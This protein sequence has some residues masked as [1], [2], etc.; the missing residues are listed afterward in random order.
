MRVIAL[1]TVHNEERFIGNCLDHLLRQG[2][3]AYLIDHGSTDAT[4]AIARRYLHHG[5]VGMETMPHDGVFSLCHQLERKEELASRLSA[6]WFMHADADEVRLAPC[7]GQ[8]LQEALTQADDEGYSAVNFLEFAFTP[9]LEQPHHD[10]AEYE[11]TMRWYY[12]F[13]QEYPHRLNAWKKQAGRVNL[14]AHGGHRV[15]FPGLRQYPVDFPMRHYLFL[16]VEHAVE[17]Y[18]GRC[19]DPREV[20][21][22]AWHGWRARL[23]N[24]DLRLPSCRQ[25]RVYCSDQ[26]LDWSG[27]R[28]AHWLVEL[29][30]ALAAG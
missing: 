25:L 29:N 26:E 18:T 4:A 17:K 12:P 8:T 20:N 7:A 6:D 9:T 19:Y 22:L 3:E 27:A 16:S 15:H 2:V 30:P 14:A 21:Q 24:G 1:L 13:S 23:Q 5:L 28:Q 11:R 10:H